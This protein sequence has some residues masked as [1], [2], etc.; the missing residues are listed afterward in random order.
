MEFNKSK[1]NKIL[2]IIYKHA[3]GRR[4]ESLPDQLTFNNLDKEIQN[5]QGKIEPP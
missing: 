4:A 1:R 3:T 2:S 5:E